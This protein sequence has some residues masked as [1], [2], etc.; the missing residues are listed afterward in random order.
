MISL[1]KK[2]SAFY[3]PYFLFL[4]CGAVILVTVD[5]LSIYQ[6]I[7]THHCTIADLF[8]TYW[9]NLG[10]GWLVIPVALILAFVSLRDVIIAV[11]C[12]LVSFTI[13]DSIKW[14]A[15]T[16]RPAEVFEQLH[17]TFYAVPNVELYHWNSFPSGHTATSFCLFSLLALI[18]SKK[19]LKFILFLV[20]FLV[21]YSRMYLSEHFLIDVYFASI[22][23]VLT[24]LFLYNAIMKWQ[25]LNKL[26]IMSKPLI[27]LQTRTQ[28]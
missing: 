1:V 3:L 26:P 11:I 9:T 6:F 22:I 2:N 23:G 16:P 10:L 4:L 28:Q 19:Y 17:Q 25:W 21:A 5:K 27:N 20:A 14:I 12:F 8:F 24:T 18:A 7:N 13:N 15:R